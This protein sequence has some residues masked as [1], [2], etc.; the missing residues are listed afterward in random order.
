MVSS[1]T[2]VPQSVSTVTDRLTLPISHWEP[3]ATPSCQTSHGVS[4]RPR[5]RNIAITWAFW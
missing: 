4:A 3:F 2:S 5:R 1:F